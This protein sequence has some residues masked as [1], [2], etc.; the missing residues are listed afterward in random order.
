MS[1]T[2]VR[3]VTTCPSVRL[4]PSSRTLKWCEGTAR[5][6]SIGRT[7]MTL[8]V[9]KL[10]SRRSKSFLMTRCSSVVKGCKGSTCM[11]K[12][13][14]MPEPVCPWKYEQTTSPLFLGFAVDLCDVDGANQFLRLAL[15]EGD[16][17]GPPPEEGNGTTRKQ[18]AW[19]HTGFQNPMHVKVIRDP[20]DLAKFTVAYRPDNREVWSEAFTRADLA[21]ATTGFTGAVSA[22]GSMSS[23]ES[24]R[25]ALLSNLTIETCA[26]SCGELEAQLY[27]GQVV[28]PCDTIVDCPATCGHGDCHYGKCL[29]C[30]NV[31]LTPEQQTWECGEVQQDCVMANGDV[32]R[33]FIPVGQAR[34]TEHYVCEDHKWFCPKPSKWALMAEEGKECGF[35]DTDCGPVDLFD[36]PFGICVNNRCE[37]TPADFPDT[38]N[39]GW[40]SD[41]CGTNVTF[42]SLFGHCTEGARCFDNMCCTPKT[43]ADFP[44]LECGEAS[45]GC[46]GVIKAMNGGGPFLTARADED[47]GW[48]YKTSYRYSNDGWAGFVFEMKETTLVG[49]LGRAVIGEFQD[50]LDV[51]LFNQDREELGRVTIGPGIPVDEQ[52]YAYA[53]LDDA[54]ELQIGRRYMLLLRLKHGMSEDFIRYNQGEA[55]SDSKI[56]EYK[57]GATSFWRDDVPNPMSS[58][59][60]SWIGVGLANFK[61]FS[62]ECP[63]DQHCSAEGKCLAAE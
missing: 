22:G 33:E 25:I 43:R 32:L 62:P 40:Q 18:L 49:H 54:V 14:L 45:D 61:V 48:V 39:C 2:L 9:E 17:V 35:V 52:L 3:R 51:A 15:L 24:Y 36:C 27:C 5:P 56:A 12:A 53:A 30:D 29:Q 20:V 7:W 6:E 44:D 57:G 19:V 10:E 37:C 23:M 31:T 50:T 47:H 46:G 55:P 21:E 58:W 28:T 34:P 42:G 13:R 8:S 41:G 26:A 16:G 1:H 60:S 63:G 59:L 4:R 11:Q 38:H